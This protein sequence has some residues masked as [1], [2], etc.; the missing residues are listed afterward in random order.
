MNFEQ[1]Y[2]WNPVCSFKFDESEIK[3]PTYLNFD[4]KMISAMGPYIVFYSGTLN[5]TLVL[6]TALPWQW[7]NIGQLGNSQKTLDLSP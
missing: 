5:H 4:G 7:W 6:H 3:F 1:W 2:I